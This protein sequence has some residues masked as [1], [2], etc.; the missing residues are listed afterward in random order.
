M[1]PAMAEGKIDIEANNWGSKSK[2]RTQA[3]NGSPNG[4]SEVGMSV[5]RPATA[6]VPATDGNPR[7]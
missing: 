5:V 3:E 7:P 1:G 2:R 4:T 6:M